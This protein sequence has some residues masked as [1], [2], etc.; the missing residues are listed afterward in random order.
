MGI[1]SLIVPP[2]TWP[3]DDASPGPFISVPSAPLRAGRAGRE[4]RSPPLPRVPV[5]SFNASSRA[6]SNASPKLRQTIFIG[7]FVAS[8]SMAKPNHERRP[9]VL[10]K[11]PKGSELY[12]DV[13]VA[14]NIIDETF[15]IEAKGR[16]RV[17][18]LTYEALHRF[19]RRLD[20]AVLVLRRRRW[21]ERRV[22]SIVDLEAARVDHYEIEDLKRV[23]REEAKNE[24]RA[25]VRR[26]ANMAEFLE[27]RDPDFHGPEIDRLRKFLGGADRP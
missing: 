12:P 19:E 17:I 11:Q 3:G 6:A 5:S 2:S 13:A 26:A 23:Q 10:E 20:A 7:P 27:T 15:D 4:A 25:S 18:A 16:A 9:T 8:P 1:I 24:F 14:R 22:R 21:T